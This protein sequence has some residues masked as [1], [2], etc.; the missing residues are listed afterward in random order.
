MNNLE[1]TYVSV[2]EIKPAEYNPKRM[3]DRERKMI[4]ESMKRFGFAQPLIVNSWEKR[5]NVLIDGHQRLIVA[6]EDLKM[7]KVPVCYVYVDS[8]EREK[9]LNLRFTKN[10]V[11]LDDDLLRSFFSEEELLQVGFTE[12]ELDSIF[13]DF[14]AQSFNDDNRLDK[15][16]KKKYLVTCPWCGHEFSSGAN[17]SAEA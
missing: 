12:K 4:L 1:V 6:I 10:S 9:E 17:E 16:D 8:L 2:S 13:I 3:N 5:K 7:K 11:D 14:D 15:F